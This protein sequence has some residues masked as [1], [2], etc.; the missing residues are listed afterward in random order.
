[1]ELVNDFFLTGKFREVDSYF[2]REST[3]EKGFIAVVPLKENSFQKVE[4]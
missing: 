2:W 4:M 1:M 3:Y